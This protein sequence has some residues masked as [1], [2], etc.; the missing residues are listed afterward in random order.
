MTRDTLPLCLAWQRLLENRS[1]P[2]NPTYETLIQSGLAHQQNKRVILDK[3]EALADLVDRHCAK[4]FHTQEKAKAIANRLG[5]NLVLDSHPQEC[6]DLLQ[7]LEDRS[8]FPAQG[9]QQQVSAAVFGDSKFLGKTSILKRI[10]N[11]WLSIQPS[12]GELRIRAFSPIMHKASGLDLNLI[13]RSFGSALLDPRT[14]MHPEAFSLEGIPKVVT[15]ENLS[16]FR[17]LSLDR[18]L[19][20]YS[21]G[22]ASRHL[23]VWLAALPRECIWRHFGDLDADGLFIFEDLLDKSGRTGSFVPDPDSIEK[24]QVAVGSWRGNREMNPQ[25][26]KHETVRELA[27]ASRRLGLQIEQETLLAACLRQGLPLQDIGLDGARLD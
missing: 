9:S 10:W 25:R 20:I 2:F 27:E 1:A 3:P 4:A 6:L 21:Q 13:T 12:R 19:L 15:C 14:A 16:P 11:D 5:L 8:D 17:Q 26:Y 18:G 23:G 24:F 22:Y 7:V